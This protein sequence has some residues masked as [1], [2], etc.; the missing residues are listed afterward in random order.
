M[1][2][3]RYERECKT[4]YRKFVNLA[5]KILRNREDAEDAVTEAFLR[6]FKAIHTYQGEYPFENWMMRIVSRICLDHRRN[7]ARRIR[8]YNYDSA[9]FVEATG[10]NLTPEFESHD[11]S[12]EDIV[13]AKLAPLW[14]DLKHVLTDEQ[15]ATFEAIAIM[16]LSHAEASEYLGA[17]PGTLRSRMSR[18]RALLQDRFT[19][20]LTAA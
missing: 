11:P 15:R 17:N 6:G 8:Y 10:D 7:Q 5:S 18:T 16:G 20:Y 2:K 4:H 13:L 3:D 9:V 12:P 1:T 19:E 14:D